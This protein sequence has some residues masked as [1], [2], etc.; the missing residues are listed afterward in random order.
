MKI[1]HPLWLTGM[2]FAT[3]LFGTDANE[4]ADLKHFRDLAETRSYTLGRPVSPRLTQDGSAV[5]FLRAGPR[6]PVLRL[7]ELTIATGKE[8]ELLT[9]EQLLGAQEEKLSVEEKARRERARV[10]LKGF[11]RFDLSQDGTRLLVTLA[12]KLYVVN[13]ADLKITEVPGTNWLDP[14]FSPDGRSVAAVKDRELHLIDLATTLATPVTKGAT[15]FISHATAE[16]IAQEE[17]ERREGYWWSPDSQW[18]AYQE[19]DESGVEVRYIADPFNPQTAPTKFFYPKAGSPNAKVRLGIIA[20]TGGPTTWITWDAEKYPYLA[21]VVWDVAAAP[22]CILV[23]NRAQTEQHL[24]KV[25]PT[26]GA[27]S[28]LLRE[29]DSAWLNLDYGHPMPVW[30][31]DGQSFLWTTERGGTWQVELH[32]ASGTLIRA[33]TPATFLYRSFV[34]IDE[35]NRQIIVRGSLDSREIQLRQFPLAGGGGTY[36]THGF[37]SHSA[38]FS[39]ESGRLIHSYELFDG[40]AGTEILSAAGKVLATL[41]SV[42]ETLPARPT[43]E[44]VKTKSPLSFDAALTR[45]RHFEPQKKYPVIL[46]VYAGPTAKTV[47][48]VARSY[49]T[50]QW[51]ADQGYI[52]VRLD[53]RGTPWKGR[54]WERVIKGNF[55]DIALTDQIAGLQALAAQFPELDLAHVGV[56][57]WSFGGYFSAMATIRRPDIFHAGIAGAPVIT[58]ANY[59]THYTERYLGLPQASPEAYKVSDVTT[60]AS[61]LRRP[62]LLIHGLTDDNVY[63]QHTLQLAD[64]LFMAGKSY[65]LMPMMGTHLAGSSDPVVRLREAQRVIEF[66]NR[67][68]KNAEVKAIDASE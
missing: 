47:N 33:L 34:G 51:T 37:G 60:Y 26:T 49:L 30:L 27:T 22:L 48:A 45:P 28:P 40:H 9:P 36:L 59:D 31:K 46:E 35:A 12:G 66:F 41:R 65:E 18:L 62:L 39:E 64:A 52:V 58:W 50:D 6:S 17:M 8:R 42:A 24:L 21:R 4:A 10:S 44:L 68:L 20:R 19:T 3:V 11:T 57:G 29:T 1:V 5:I 38:K 63:F 53:G 61:E 23:Q 67:H 16:F 14:R 7:Y 32:D 25:D 2:L 13:R 56:K 55:I 43:T 15:E 54:A